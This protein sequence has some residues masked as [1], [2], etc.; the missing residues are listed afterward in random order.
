MMEKVSPN[1]QI[2]DAEHQ[3]G[4]LDALFRR[5]YEQMVRLAF[6]LLGNN[7]E[8]E[9]I[10]QDS[11]VEVH[12]RLGTISQPGAYL[13][14]TVVRRC[15]SHLRRR[16]TAVLHRER[17]PTGLPPAAGELWDVLAKLPQQQRFVIVLKYYGRY[18][19]SEIAQLIE[20]PASSV[21][22]Q[23]RRGL[24]ALRKELEQ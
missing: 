16:R 1:E 12:R 6:T 13:R 9:E 21:R 17:P 10:V 19:A 5:E 18:R 22:S 2:V 3:R 4:V 15:Y 24:A 20:V 8:A 7:A 14:T 11:F 23:L